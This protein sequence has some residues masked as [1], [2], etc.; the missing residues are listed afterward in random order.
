MIFITS[1]TADVLELQ[2]ISEAAAQKVGAMNKMADA[3][4]VED[5]GECEYN[6]VCS[7]V[8]E[9]RAMRKK[10]KNEGTNA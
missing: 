2:Q 7:D 9:L 3:M 10:N 6:D 8:A 1:G 4:H 5:C